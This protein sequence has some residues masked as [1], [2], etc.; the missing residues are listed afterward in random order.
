VISVANPEQRERVAAAIRRALHE[1]TDRI[2]SDDQL[3]A[4]EEIGAQL[5]AEVSAGRTRTL[6][7]RQQ[8]FAEQMLDEIRDG[9]EFS[10]FAE[11]PY[12]GELNPVSP[13]TATYRREGDTIVGDVVIGPAYTGA[14]GRAHGGTVA[15]VFD[16]AMG[17]VQRLSSHV[18]YTR[19]LTVN[20]RAPF[21]IDEV[22]RI[23]AFESR[24]DDKIFVV[25]A[26]AEAGD[27]LVA[28][29]AASFTRVDPGRFGTH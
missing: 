1:F 8:V 3:A 21:P 24:F 20:Y 11:S 27:K 13:I 10:P 16:D 15:A 25:E 9:D 26:K 17:A 4:V 19:E 14:P 22:V 5:E 7:E 29:A 18:G 28:E 23:T 2:F 12:S 6:E